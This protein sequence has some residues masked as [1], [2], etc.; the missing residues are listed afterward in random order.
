M[1]IELKIKNSPK[2]GEFRLYL[3]IIKLLYS[4]K[5]SKTEQ[6]Q[7]LVMINF[8][9]NILNNNYIKIGEYSLVI[10]IIQQEFNFYISKRY[11]KLVTFAL[12]IILLNAQT[13]NTPF[14]FILSNCNFYGFCYVQPP[15]HFKVKNSAQ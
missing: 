9:V 14:N 8:I 10:Q 1:F 12:Q 15:E 13:C 11:F 7:Q 5:L 6:V 3:K 2:N 4:T